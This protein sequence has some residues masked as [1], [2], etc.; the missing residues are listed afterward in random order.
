MEHVDLSTE[1]TVHFDFLGKDSIRY[2]NTVQVDKKVFRNLKR[3]AKGLKKTDQLFSEL[4]PQKLNAY[5]HSFMEGLTAKVR[6][7]GIVPLVCLS[8]GQ[9]FRTYN[10]SITLDEKLQE[11]PDDLSLADKVVFY[12]MAN[13]DVAILCN[14]QRALPKVSARMIRPNA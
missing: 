12:N 10:A 3:F 11:M 5:L 13:R 4:N 1:N 8:L 14:H 6:F 2:E 7:E 9:V